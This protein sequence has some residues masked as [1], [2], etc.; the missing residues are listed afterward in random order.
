MRKVVKIHGDFPTKYSPNPKQYGRQL[1]D[2]EMGFVM[3][4][5][6]GKLADLKVRGRQSDPRWRPRRVYGEASRSPSL[7]LPFY[8]CYAGYLHPS[9]STV[10]PYIHNNLIMW[11]LLPRRLPLLNGP[12]GVTYLEEDGLESL[13][14]G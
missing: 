1:N 11:R 3:S 7:S 5:C 4:M 6:Q 14:P 10:L 9:L 2:D 12:S 8:A 13:P